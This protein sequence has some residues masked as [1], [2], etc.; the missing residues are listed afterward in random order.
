MSNLFVIYNKKYNTRI[1]FV[2]KKWL[3]PLGVRSSKLGE[4]DFL[5]DWVSLWAG[6][7]GQTAA[8]VAHALGEVPGLV[9]VQ[10]MRV[11][12]PHND[13]VFPGTG[14]QPRKIKTL[15]R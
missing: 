1:Q 9:D 8:V 5:S 11:R 2:V 13:I 6:R 7:D 4:P 14:R 15:S 10:V 3:Y 12:G